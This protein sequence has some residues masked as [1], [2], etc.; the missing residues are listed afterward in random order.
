M[1][2]P[3]MVMAA[4][5]GGDDD[6]RGLVTTVAKLGWLS[7]MALIGEAAPDPG[8][9]VDVGDVIVAGSRAV[10]VVVVVWRTRGDVAALPLA[11]RV[12]TR[13]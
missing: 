10:V 11:G 7:C 1:G 12:R 9:R 5:G 8:E 13:P 2:R 6:D 3:E 4:V